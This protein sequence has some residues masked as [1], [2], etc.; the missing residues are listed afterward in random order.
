MLDPEDKFF[1]FPLT[2][3]PVN[4][5]NYILDNNYIS[6][7]GSPFFLLFPRNSSSNKKWDSRV[8]KSVHFESMRSGFKPE[9]C[10]LLAI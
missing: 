9:V 7:H 4:L 10:H 6:H 1:A 2:S 8:D 5:L 3:S